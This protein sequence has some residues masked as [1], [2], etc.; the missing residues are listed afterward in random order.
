MFR[1]FN[2]LEANLRN[3]VLIYPHN[4]CANWVL[5]LG[6]YRPQLIIFPRLW[7]GE[8]ADTNHAALTSWLPRDRR[9]CIRGSR[10]RRRQGVKRCLHQRIGCTYIG[11]L[12]LQPYAIDSEQAAKHRQRGRYGPWYPTKRNASRRHWND[13]FGFRRYLTHDAL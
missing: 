5:V 2:R 11:K 3:A 9:F 7:R 4:T 8:V 12:A 13:P 1:F 6:I 10:R